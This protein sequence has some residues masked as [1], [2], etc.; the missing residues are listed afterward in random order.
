MIMDTDDEF[1]IGPSGDAPRHIDMNNAGRVAFRAHLDSGAEGIFVYSDA[2]GQ[3]TPF[4]DTTG[5]FDSVRFPS[6]SNGGT[7]AF[8]AT[9]DAGGGQ[10]V[11]RGP[12]PVTDKIIAVGDVFQPRTGGP[13]TVTAISFGNDSVAK[14][15][16]MAFTVTDQFG[17]Q[18]LI[19]GGPGLL[20][21]PNS[22]L[23]AQ[24]SH[25]DE[26]QERQ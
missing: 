9:L 2:T 3:V 5:P 11:F 1:A 26:Q 25:R 17:E 22:V 15:G 7:V 24:L 23:V 10:G 20:A 18:F 4:V 19:S 12:N 14:L 13:R 6:I 8:L 16:K 21:D